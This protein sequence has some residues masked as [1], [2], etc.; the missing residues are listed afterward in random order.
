[1]N[2][3]SD[4]FTRLAMAQPSPVSTR[5]LPGINVPF[6]WPMVAAAQMTEQGMDLYARNR[7]FLGRWISN[8]NENPAAPIVKPP[9]S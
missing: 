2:E 8:T 1:M 7:K 5:D 3:V 9:K 4:H 6:F